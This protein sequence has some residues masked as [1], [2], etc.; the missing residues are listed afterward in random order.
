MQE[1]TLTLRRLRADDMFTMMRLLSKLGVQDI[2]KCFSEANISGDTENDGLNVALAI[3][4]LLL[5]KLP[6]CKGEIYALL[7][8]L[9]GLTAEEIAM[10]DMV[11]FTNAVLDLVTA[12]DFRDFFTAVM[13]RFKRE[14]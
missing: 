13:K 5:E 2:R 3:G 7:S 14:K 10:M 1:N 12:E 8:D 4:G 11:P 6:G 9:S